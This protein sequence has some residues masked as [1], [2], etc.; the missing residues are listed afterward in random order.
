MKNKA[1]YL[2]LIIKQFFRRLYYTTKWKLEDVVY[3]IKMFN[4]NLKIWYLKNIKYRKLY[5]KED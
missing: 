1:G 2:L 4:I 3:K 5:K